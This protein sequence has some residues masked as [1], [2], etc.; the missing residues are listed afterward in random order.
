[1]NITESS[2]LYHDLEQMDTEKLLF[3]INQEDQKVAAAVSRQLKSIEVFVDAVYTCLNTGGRL[4]YIGAGT[5]GRLGVVDASE[6]PPTFGVDKNQVIGIIAGGDCALRVAKEGAEDDI[7]LAWRELLSYQ[8]SEKDIVLGISS[9]GRTPYVLGGISA[10]KA[11]GIKTGVL[12]C[13]PESPLLDVAD[14]AIEVVVGPE[15]VSGSTRMKAGTAQKMVLNMISTCI[16]IKLGKVR[17][18]KMVDMK[19]SNDKLRKRAKRM[20]IDELN[21]SGEEAEK[22]LEIHGSVRVAIDQAKKKGITKN[23]SIVF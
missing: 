7:Y 5:S 20:L 6:C 14:M 15:F 22:L 3:S 16:M 17:G 2:S 21:I 11:A 8:I 9:S 1:M 23:S 19:L 10:C 13:N 12:V 4:F 18:N